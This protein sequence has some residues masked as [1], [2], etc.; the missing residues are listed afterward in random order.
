MEWLYSNGIGTIVVSSG[1]FNNEGRTEFIE[2][3]I[4]NTVQKSSEL[5][6]QF[7][8]P[9]RF[10]L[11]YLLSRKQK[12][13]IL[14][15]L[16]FRLVCRW[17]N[18]LWILVVDT[19]KREPVLYISQWRQQIVFSTRMCLFA[20]VVMMSEWSRWLYWA[21]NIK[22]LSFVWLWWWL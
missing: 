18:F 20:S 4:E 15:D 9:I 2:N 3:I 13:I 7:R 17:E 6:R 8:V 21:L 16:L 22:K 5:D 12:V 14:V 10:E 1:E 11:L 19:W